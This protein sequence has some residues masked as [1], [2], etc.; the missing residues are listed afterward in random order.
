MDEDLRTAVTQIWDGTK[1]NSTGTTYYRYYLSPPNTSSSSS[2]SSSSSIRNKGYPSHQGSSAHLPKYVLY[3]GSYDRLAADPAVTNPLTAPDSIVALYADHYFEFDAQ[4]RCTKE[5][6][7]GG[8]QTF[9]F[10]Y[11][12]GP[13]G[14]DY[15][16]WQTKTVETLPDGSQNIIYSNAASQTILFVYQSGSNQ[17]IHYYRYDSLGELI[18]HASPSAVTGFSE[19]YPDLMNYSGG[20]SPYLRTSAGLIF[21]Y[22]Y[23]AASKYIASESLKQ[24]TSGTPI[25]RRE[26][27]YTSCSSGGNSSSSSSS[28]LSSGSSS[29]SSSDGVWFVSKETVYPS[30]TDQTQTLVTSFAYSF[31]PG[32]CGIQ[33]KV[34]TLPAVSAAQNGSGVAAAIKE[35]YDPFG[36]LTWTMDERGL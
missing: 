15:N 29:S 35:Y 13:G 22:T 31:Y 36:N 28:S 33:Q 14:S 27:Q 5:V 18:L 20:T 3:P 16:T 25:K 19:A 30:D 10:S 2:S 7:N 24:G 34:I 8:S 1:W 6:I 4:R 11:S 9:L 17:W 21:L 12:S 26:F 23:D 32:T